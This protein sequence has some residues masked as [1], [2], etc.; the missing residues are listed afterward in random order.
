MTVPNRGDEYEQFAYEKFSKLFATAVVT[1]NDHIRGHQSGLNREI[2]VSVRM[3][4]G[5]AELLYVVQCK[6]WKT[7]ADI[8][9]LGEFSAVIQDIRAAKGFLLCTAGFA[10]S[11]HQYA[12]ALGIELVTIEDIKSEKWKAD[13]QIPFVYIQKVNN[14]KMA[15]AFSANEA[16]IEKNRDKELLIQITTGTPLTTDD[17]ATTVRYQD[18]LERST[19]AIES[20]LVICAERDIRQPNL[21]IEIAG[22]WVPCIEFSV[23][24]IS[25]SR[26]HYLKYL[27]PDEYSHLKDHVRGT[28]LPLHWMVKNVGMALDDTFVEWLGAE[29][30]VFPGLSLE[31]EES[32][33][34]EMAQRVEGCRP[35]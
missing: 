18:Y 30:P 3:K 11:N 35:I 10:K 8:K 24:L 34:S 22:V 12:I 13:V 7:P 20:T 29:P 32:T 21:H 27:T 26:K 14:L 19:M 16:L 5:D 33:V 2:D 23:T 1:K 31:V 6:D 28:M 17:G 15:L 4:A 25:I 9:V